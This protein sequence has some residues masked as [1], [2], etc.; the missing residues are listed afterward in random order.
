MHH[1]S[2]F[3]KD[4]TNDSLYMRKSRKFFQGGGPHPPLDPRML[5]MAI[6][7]PYSEPL[8]ASET[9]DSDL[10]SKPVESI[11]IPPSMYHTLKFVGR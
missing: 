11:S 5:Y 4:G 8:Q 10:V 2:K 7:K 6:K 9:F 3:G 1:S